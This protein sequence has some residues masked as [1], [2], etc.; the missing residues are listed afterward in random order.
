MCQKSES[1]AQL[2]MHSSWWGKAQNFFRLA[3]QLV[4]LGLK[5]SEYLG[6][7]KTNEAWQCEQRSMLILYWKMCEKDCIFQ[8]IEIQGGCCSIVF[9]W[10]DF[11]LRYDWQRIQVFCSFWGKQVFIFCSLIFSFIIWTTRVHLFCFLASKNKKFESI[12]HRF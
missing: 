12:P 5:E 2:P 8:M 4:L 10:W 9:Y 3:A 1:H 7:F 6:R 11:F